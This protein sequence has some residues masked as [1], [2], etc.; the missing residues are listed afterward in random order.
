MQCHTGRYRRGPD[1][2]AGA[3]RPDRISVHRR[4]LHA[5]NYAA[6]QEQLLAMLI[7]RCETVTVLPYGYVASTAIRWDGA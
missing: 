4:R 2:E 5:G 3:G 6:M 7:R 1:R